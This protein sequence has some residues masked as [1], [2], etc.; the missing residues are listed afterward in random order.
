M[1]FLIQ[2]SEAL[3]G[4]AAEEEDEDDHHANAEV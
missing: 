2:L 1:D 4:T 3:T